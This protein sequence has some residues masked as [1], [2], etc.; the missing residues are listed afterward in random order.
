MVDQIDRETGW[1]KDSFDERDYSIA[2]AS[3]KLELETPS[4]IE[5]LFDLI[6]R[7]VDHLPQEIHEKIWEKGIE[8]EASLYKLEKSLKKRIT[9][10]TATIS[11]QVHDPRLHTQLS[12]AAIPAMIQVF[13]KS[14]LEERNLFEN[15]SMEFMRFAAP[16]AIR[17]TDTNFAEVSASIAGAIQNQIEQG[18]PTEF[19]RGL[20]LLEITP[21]VTDSNQVVQLP[22]SHFCM[23]DG[24][25]ALPPVVDLSYYCSPVEDQTPHAACCAHA[26]VALLEFFYRRTYNDYIHLS[27]RFLHVVSRKLRNSPPEERGSSTRDTIRAMR[28]FG[29]PPESVWPYQP[30]TSKVFDQDPDSFCY[31]YAQN[32]QALKF[33]RL[34][35]DLP[36]DSPAL[37]DAEKEQLNHKLLVQVKAFL[38]AGFPLMFGFFFS[39]DTL[40]MGADRECV[41]PAEQSQPSRIEYEANQQSEVQRGHAVLAVGYDDYRKA[42]LIQN[43]WGE[44]WGLGGYGW[45]PYDYVL[46]GKTG[47]WWSLLQ[48]EWIDRQE[49]GLRDTVALAELGPPGLTT[50][51]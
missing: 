42:I 7:V 40:N 5:Q 26:G 29:V 13:R 43:S 28:I 47:D 39:G 18:I 27:R 37:T 35:R 20:T 45:L 32:Y 19:E 15:H 2:D 3:S 38:A 48:A 17:L 25:M 8:R 6:K 34:D 23:T 44:A 31:A 12:P 11:K 9:F 4:D 46:Q 41:I 30:D 10:V 16:G 36:E 51:C 1:I 24:F 22:I 21:Q 14:S 49:F 33:F 50:G